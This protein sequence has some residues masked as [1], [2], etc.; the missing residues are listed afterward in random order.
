MSY[1]P[2]QP[3][4][5]QPPAGQ[6]PGAAP[7]EAGI[8]PGSDSYPP[9]PWGYYQPPEAEATGGYVPPP[10]G[11][12]GGAPQGHTPYSAQYYGP[13]PG[14][15]PASTSTWAIA[16]LAASIVSWLLVPFVL[17]VVGVICGHIALNEI[18]RSQGR[19]EGRGMALAG[20]I[21]GYA[22]IAAAVCAIV[23]LIA[24]LSTRF[25]PTPTP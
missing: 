18:N 24:L 20:L 7:G 22:N 13:Y 25:S 19:L 12:P 10:Y 5:N 1:D 9:P 11:P 3:G 15:M 6:G 17:A 23:F 21:I 8:T 4:W 2:N 16:S 14:P